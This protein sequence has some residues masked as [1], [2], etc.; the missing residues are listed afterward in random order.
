M[1]NTNCLEDIKCPECGNEDRFRIAA[2]ALF[3]VTDNGTDD[4]TDV[5]WDDDSH[6]ECVECHRPGTIRDFKPKPS[7]LPPDPDGMNFD[8]ASWADKAISAFREATGAD[9]DEALSDLLADLMHWADRTGYRFNE[10]LDRARSHYEAETASD[11]PTGH[12]SGRAHRL[13]SNQPPI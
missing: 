3:T 4:Y 5:E 2:T 10:A 13:S 7:P 11:C 9:R 1:T 8:R 6:A 12:R